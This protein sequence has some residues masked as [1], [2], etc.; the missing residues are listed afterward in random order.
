MS[1]CDRYFFAFDVC[2]NRKVT[3]KCFDNVDGLT[4]KLF[5]L[6]II[7]FFIKI[8]C[9]FPGI[10][11]LATYSILLVL[12]VINAKFV[13]GCMYSL[14]DSYQKSHSLDFIIFTY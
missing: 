9:H 4:E 5:R 14:V 13:Y 1:T 10:S 11:D 12:G 6:C 8:N 3:Y 2:E 7:T